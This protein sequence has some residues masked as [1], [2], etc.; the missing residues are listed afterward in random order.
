M[1]KYVRVIALISLIVLGSIPVAF[2]L[3]PH[4]IEK[5]FYADNTYTGDYVGYSFLSCN[6][7]T[8]RVGTQTAYYDLYTD[9]CF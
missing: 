9:P 1:R 5:D 3:P 6:G 8:T 7:H 4:S 2:A